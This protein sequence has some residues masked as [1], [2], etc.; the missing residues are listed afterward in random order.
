VAFSAERSAADEPAPGGARPAARGP[1]GPVGP[2]R[3]R[4]APVEASP[5]RLRAHLHDD[6]RRDPLRLPER[7]DDSVA[8]HRFEHFEAELGLIRLD[9]EH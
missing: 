7:D 4:T 8:L 3:R 6:H 2:V 1:V 5:G 9:H